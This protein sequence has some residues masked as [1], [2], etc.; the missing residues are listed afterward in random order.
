[1]ISRKCPNSS[2]HPTWSCLSGPRQ[3]STSDSTSQVGWPGPNCLWS[4]WSRTQ[5][6]HTVDSDHR[7]TCTL[8][9]TCPH[10][11]AEG[12]SYLNWMSLPYW[13]CVYSC[14]WPAE[15]LQCKD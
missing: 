15:P 5:K 1:M 12:E 11:L 13:P 6:R 7:V 10:M 4:V 3:T 2:I 9:W 8:R 14:N